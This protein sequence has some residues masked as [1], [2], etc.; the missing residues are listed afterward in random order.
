MLMQAKKMRG[1]Q[2]EEFGQQIKEC[3]GADNVDASQEHE[4]ATRR[5]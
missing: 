1:G 5:G 2:Q 3:S 4:R